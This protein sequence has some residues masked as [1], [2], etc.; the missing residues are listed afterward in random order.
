MPYCSRFRWCNKI[1]P[2][3]PYPI[4]TYCW[5]C[6]SKSGYLSDCAVGLRF[7]SS[8]QSLTTAGLARVSPTRLITSSSQIVTVDTTPLPSTLVTNKTELVQYWMKNV[9]LNVC[10]SEFNLF[11]YTK[12]FHTRFI[13]N[14]LKYY[15][16]TKRKTPLW[17][18]DIFRRFV[19]Q[20]D[21]TIFFLQI[22]QAWFSFK[23]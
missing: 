15:A 8:T 21:G 12:F 1:N 18:A 4:W 22:S 6:C 19:C 3:W 23:S 14:V 5:L 16:N 20:R 17:F 10:L 13:Q 7:D 11:Q 9:I 2:L